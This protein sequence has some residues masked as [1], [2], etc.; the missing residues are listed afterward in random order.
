MSD[1]KPDVIYLQDGDL[2]GHAL[3][4][5][6]A[7]EHVTWC[8]T[9]MYPHDSALARI[10]AYI[11]PDDAVVVSKSM[12]RAQLRDIEKA[13]KEL[14]D[15]DAAIASLAEKLEAAEKRAEEAGRDKAET[16]TLYFD[17][18]ARLADAERKAGEYATLIKKAQQCGIASFKAWGYVTQ[19][20]ALTPPDAEEAKP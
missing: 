16:D 11:E 19:A 2:D 12:R 3:T 9:R 13:G 15:Q 18:Q 6:D 10:P 1:E 8:I 7:C 14:A 20:A 4:D 17:A 5:K